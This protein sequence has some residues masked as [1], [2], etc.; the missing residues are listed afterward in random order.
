[1]F[2]SLSHSL[3]FLVNKWIFMI[4]LFPFLHCLCTNEMSTCNVTSILILIS[5]VIK[6]LRLFFVFVVVD[7]WFIQFY[8]RR[9]ADMNK[10]DNGDD[11]KKWQKKKEVKI[12]RKCHFASIRFINTPECS[13][14]FFIR[15]FC[16]FLMVALLAYYIQSLIF[17]FRCGVYL[18][19]L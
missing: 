15:F 12:N 1:M 18:I 17:D 16:L 7:V 14:Q 3:L 6:F 10:I 4:F 13:F 19:T 2:Y 11:K 8:F 9:Y 5:W